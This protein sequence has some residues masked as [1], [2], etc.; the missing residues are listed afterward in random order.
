MRGPS[1]QLRLV[2]EHSILRASAM[3][4]AEANFIKLRGI[5]LSD[6]RPLQRSFRSDERN[7]TRPHITHDTRGPNTGC[8]PESWHAAVE[9]PK[10]P[11][12]TCK[13]CCRLH[14]SL[15]Q[16]CCAYEGSWS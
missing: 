6:S 4:L 9:S 12:E 2:V 16:P 13:N 15:D 1:R 3:A 11:S 7:E 8:D 14:D 10:A 5:I